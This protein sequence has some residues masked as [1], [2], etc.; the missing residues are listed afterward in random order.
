MGITFGTPD[1]DLQKADTE[2]LIRALLTTDGCGRHKKMLILAL[3]IRRNRDGDLIN[4][5]HRAYH[6]GR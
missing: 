4:A 2:D 3:L 5:I 1:E 6:Q